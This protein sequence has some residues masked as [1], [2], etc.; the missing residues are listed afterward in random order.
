MKNRQVLLFG[1]TLWAL[2]ETPTLAQDCK[3]H[4][5]EVIPSSS[6]CKVFHL[7]DFDFRILPPD[8]SEP[9][10]IR[11]FCKRYEVQSTSSHQEVGYCYTGEGDRA[12]PVFKVRDKEYLADLNFEGCVKGV[13]AHG[14]LFA[15]GGWSNAPGGVTRFWPV[16]SLPNKLRCPR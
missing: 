7:P 3:F 16:Q 2:N 12:G 9:V 14:I 13:E 11:R 10:H 1:L 15:P 8:E 5:W 6:D 4:Y